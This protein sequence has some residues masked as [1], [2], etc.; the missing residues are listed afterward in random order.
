[1][2]IRLNYNPMSVMTHASLARTDRLMSGVLQRMSS[3]ERLQR[4]ADDPAAMVVANNVRYYRTGVDRAK[5]NA[6][7]AVAMLQTAEGGMDQITQTLQRMRTLAISALSTATAD[8]NQN[9]ALQ[10]ELEASIRSITTLAEGTTFGGT[11]LLNGALRDNSLSS[12]AKDYYRAL[13]SDYTKLPG[14]M[15]DGSTITINPASGPLAKSS[16][17]Q[18]FG[19]G[20]PGMTV[21]SPGP[22]SIVLSGPK[23]TATVNIAAGAT[24]DVVAAA[25]NANASLTGVVAAYDE[26]TGDLTVESSSYGNATLS[27]VSSGLLTGGVNPASDQ[28]LDITYL[29]ASGISQTV[30]LTQDAT[31]PGGLTFTNLTGG[32]EGVAPFTGFAPGA[33]SLSL[34]DTSSGAVGS[35]IT[36]AGIAVDATRSGTTAFQLGALASQRVMVE[37]PDLRAGAL[38]HSAGLAGS[39]FASLNDLLASAGPPAYAGVFVA[40][41]ATEALALIEASLNEVNRARGATGALQGSMVERVMDSLS[42]TSVNLR[43][44]EGVLRDVDMAAES[45]EYARVQVM[46]QAATAMLAQANQVPQTVLQLLK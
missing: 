41:N 29:D 1:M 20:T 18:N 6:E 21:A 8:P 7:E 24:I 39:G 23:G 46:I 32:P 34:L 19:A 2:A 13:A 30:T 14:G 17:V 31:S 37:I 43:E 22:D 36:P 38:G 40:G 16:M 5:S 12:E 4:S 10:G 11:A 28:T 35:T 26:T 42:L 45:A 9:I 27:A 3:G 25:I 44:F 33:F 15:S